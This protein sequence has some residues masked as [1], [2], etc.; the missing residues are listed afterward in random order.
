MSGK[1]R[2]GQPE[3]ENA[4]THGRHSKRRR[5]ERRLAWEERMAA[6]ENGLPRLL[7]QTTARSAA[8]F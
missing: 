5:E 1:K 2:G 8:G 3:N 7:K 4:V 6:S